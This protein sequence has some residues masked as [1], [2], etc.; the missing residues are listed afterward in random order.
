MR[1]GYVGIGVV[2]CGSIGIRGALEHF[3]H[4]DL[5]GEARITAVCDPVP[6]RAK[7]AA[8]KY[9]VPSWYDGDEG[10]ER[11]L[12][13]ADVDM[14]TLCSPI[15]LHYAQGLSAIR[16]GKHVHFN[17]TM[18]VE[19]WECDEMIAEADRQGVRIVASPGVAYAPRVQR[20]RRLVLEGRLGMLSWGYIDNG[21]GSG[22]YHLGEAV[23]QGDGPLDGISPAWY[24]KKPAGGPQ[25]DVA[26]Y[27]LHNV[28]SILGPAKRVTAFSGMQHRSHEYKGETIANEMDDSTTLLLDYGGGFHVICNSVTA[29]P[30][31]KLFSFPDIHGGEASIIGGCYKGEPLTR[32]GDHSPHAVG[33]HAD[34]Q[35]SHVFEDIMQL[36]GLIRDGGDL[37]A[38]TPE[39]ARHVVEIIEGGYRAARTGVAQALRTSFA[40][41]PLEALARL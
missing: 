13:D 33:V 41:L 23:R 3:K 28:T 31:V 19:A 38:G 8:A 32:P 20:A 14:V 27:S 11:L 35:E 1:N 36:A 7:A 16:A 12:G 10:L 37:Y 5:D 15:G 2:G 29:S 9:G 25:Y 4:G 39:Q 30:M 22:G 34:M 6:G 21:A 24:F 26:V 17:K 18:A 40:P